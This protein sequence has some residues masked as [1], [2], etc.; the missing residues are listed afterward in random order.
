MVKLPGKSSAHG[1]R[2]LP[3]AIALYRAEQQSK[4]PREALT[5]LARLA[6]D[7]NAAEAFA[8]LKLKDR[9]AE[10][11]VIAACIEAEELA[12]TFEQRAAKA[13]TRRAR[14]TRNFARLPAFSA[15]SLTSCMPNSKTLPIHCG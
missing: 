15:S 13:E 7:R 1:A 12:R 3:E 6:D 14:G 8:R 11:A 10:A 5:L 2:A 9:T 4:F